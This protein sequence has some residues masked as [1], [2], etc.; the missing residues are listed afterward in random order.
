MGPHYTKRRRWESEVR[1]AEGE[2]RR[3]VVYAP[4]SAQPRLAIVFVAGC[5]P[6]DYGHF[7]STF[8]GFEEIG[9]VMEDET[10]KMN[11]EGNA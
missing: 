1:S 6:E 3:S 4:T 9:L 10:M 11:K 7:R 2:W 5:N 8:E